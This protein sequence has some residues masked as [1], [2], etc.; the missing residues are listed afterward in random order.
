[1]SEFC[2]DLFWGISVGTS[3]LGFV[4]LYL[5]MGKVRFLSGFLRRT[6][7]GME[8]SARQRLL[9]DRIRLGQLENKHSVFL[10]L[11]R[12]IYYSGLHITF[13]KLTVEKWMVWNLLMIAF[14]FIG[15]CVFVGGMAALVVVIAFVGCE[16]MWILVQ[17]AKMMHLVNLNILKFLDFMGNYSITSGEIAGVL[18][19]VSH[20]VDEPLKTVLNECYVEAQLTGDTGMAL[21]AMAEKVEHPKFK[22][23]VRNMEISIRYCADFKVLV[24]GSRRSVREYLRMREER[25]GMLREASINMGLLLVMSIFVMLA[26]DGLIEGSI[27]RL[28]L[29]SVPGHIALGIVGGIFGLFLNKVYRM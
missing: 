22:E 17:K 12:Q 4:L 18:N 20:Y 13:P 15:G 6:R 5:R 25:K 29:Y 1:M 14:L 3:F 10:F 11:Q 8:A 2:S 26:V 16:W 23:L 21:L 27:W 28:L 7:E 9:A 24:A 19:Q